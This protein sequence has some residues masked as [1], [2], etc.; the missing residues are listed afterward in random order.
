MVS[1]W[2]KAVTA[3]VALWALP[4]LMIR[5]QP[6]HGD[7]LTQ[8]LLPPAD[9]PV[10]CFL[11]VRP[12]VTTASEAFALLEAHPWIDRIEPS[13]VTQIYRAVL[14][15]DFDLARR[16][17][18]S[19]LLRIENG[20]VR[21][22]FWQTRPFTRGDLRLAL[23]PPQT[24][25][26]VHDQVYGSVPLLMLYPQ[27]KLRIVSP[28]YICTLNQADFWRS[29]RNWNGIYIGDADEAHQNFIRSATGFLLPSSEIEPAVW[30][31]ALRD[32]NH[33]KSER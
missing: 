32:L 14:A 8:F 28:L 9:C 7:A 30:A 20:I 19:P 23:G 11:G 33:C 27:Y 3:L 25:Q 24:I 26:V 2:L 5:A 10:P 31:H 16:G 15:A 21:W 6:Y 1:L 12:G 29:Q 4:I 22:V 18:P 13:G 17:S